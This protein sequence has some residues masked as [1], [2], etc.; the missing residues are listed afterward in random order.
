MTKRLSKNKKEGQICKYCIVKRRGHVEEFDERKVYGSCYA[1]CLS[2]HVPH[3]EAE[4][5]CEKV[6]KEEAR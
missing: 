2:S 4:K 3:I 6:S 1:A 5:V